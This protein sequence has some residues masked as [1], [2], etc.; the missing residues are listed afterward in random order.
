[1]CARAE[2]IQGERGAGGAGRFCALD[3]GAGR[4][5]VEEAHRVIVSSLD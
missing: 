1:M 5:M 4:N 3:P 2:H